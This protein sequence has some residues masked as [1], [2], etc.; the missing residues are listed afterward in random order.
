M[1]KYRLYAGYH[2]LWITEKQLGRP[3]IPLSWHKSLFNAIKAAVKEDNAAVICFDRSLK[4]EVMKHYGLTEENV[5]TQVPF[6]N[7]KEYDVTKRISPVTE[8]NLKRQLDC[9]ISYHDARDIVFFL[10]SKTKKTLKTLIDTVK[11]HTYKQVFP[12]IAPF[13]NT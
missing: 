11:G 13:L 7:G 2:E 5:M 10:R 9:N 4:K 1:K 6:F 3:L 12:V 8:D